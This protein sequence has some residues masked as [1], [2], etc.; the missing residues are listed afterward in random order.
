[1][2]H[3]RM[4]LPLTIALKPPG[5]KWVRA[6]MG[7]ESAGIA[8]PGGVVRRR[9]GETG[10]V[11]LIV[12][13]TLIFASFALIVFM[14]KASNDLLVEK[15]DVETRR[16]RMEAYSALEVTLGVLADFSLVDSGLHSPAEGWGD[17]L[18]FAG[19]TPSNDRTIDIS[20]E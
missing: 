6:R 11:I 8:L 16:L 18:A 2:R 1:M 3:S 13:M 20:F 5:S 12:I 19:Y 9:A 4:I 7:P 14:D 17:P 15:R 10:S